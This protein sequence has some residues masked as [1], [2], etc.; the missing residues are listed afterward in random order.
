MSA[1]WVYSSYVI[2]IMTVIEVFWRFVILI[3]SILVNLNL[4]PRDMREYTWETGK[5]NSRISG[6]AKAIM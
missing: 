4:I 3:L 5:R 2:G 6:K 1:L